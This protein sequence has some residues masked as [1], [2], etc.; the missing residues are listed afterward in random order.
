MVKTLKIIRLLFFLLTFFIDSPKICANKFFNQHGGQIISSVIMIM[1]TF[2]PMFY[3]HFYERDPEAKELQVKAQRLLN[4]QRTLSIKELRQEVDYNS[5]SEVQK[6]NKKLLAAKAVLQSNAK[7]I[8]QELQIRA[9]ALEEENKKQ[10]IT[11]LQEINTIKALKIGDSL[12]NNEKYDSIEAG[13]L[14]RYNKLVQ[15]VDF[16]TVK[17]GLSGKDKDND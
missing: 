10:R 15:G 7:W 8:N 4:E 1:S 3:R 6:N 9:Q 14:N 16:T 5:D 13:L 11:I 17:I 2:G 12:D